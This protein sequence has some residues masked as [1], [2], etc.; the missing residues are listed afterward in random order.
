LA[1]TLAAWGLDV[2][3]DRVDLGMIF[4]AAVLAAGVLHGLRPALAAATVA[5]FI[6]NYLFLE[7]RYSLAIGAPTDFITLVVFWAVALASG[8]LAG[9]VRDQALGS[10]RRAAA[11]STLLAASRTLSAASGTRRRGPRLGRTG[12]RHGRRAL[13]GAAAAGTRRSRRRRR[14][15]AWRRWTPPRWPP[16]A[17]PGRR[18]RRPASAPAP[19]LRRAG[20]SGPWRACEPAPG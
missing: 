14:A 17:G 18:A 11:V 12:R 19:C 6:Y 15:R 1:A 4:L 5:F 20:P 9:R 3:F 7:P 16:R 10:Q 13:A 2:A 8:G